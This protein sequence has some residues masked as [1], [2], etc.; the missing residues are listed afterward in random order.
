MQP[1]LFTLNHV[2]V[3][4]GFFFFYI[5]YCDIVKHFGQLGVV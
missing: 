5:F 3:V 2:H 4:M 1:G